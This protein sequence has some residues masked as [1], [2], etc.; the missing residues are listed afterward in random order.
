MVLNLWELADPKKCNSINNL[1]R[2][3]M[4]KVVLI[5]SAL[6]HIFSYGMEKSSPFQGDYNHLFACYLSQKNKLSI[7]FDTLSSFDA[8]YYFCQQDTDPEKS[9]LS[10]LKKLSTIE[11]NKPTKKVE[12]EFLEAVAIAIVKKRFAA[13]PSGVL[14]NAMQHINIGKIVAHFTPDRA[15]KSTFSQ[16]VEERAHEQRALFDSLV[17]PIDGNKQDIKQHIKEQITQKIKEK[18]VQ[19]IAELEHDAEN[20][21]LETYSQRIVSIHN[22]SE[23]TN[24]T[25]FFATFNE[26]SSL[27]PPDKELFFAKLYHKTPCLKEIFKQF[28]SPDNKSITSYIS[29]MKKYLSSYIPQW[30]SHMSIAENTANPTPQHTSTFL[31]WGLEKIAHNPLNIEKSI[32]DNRAKFSIKGHSCQIYDHS[33]FFKIWTTAS[34]L[35]GG[36]LIDVVSIDGKLALLYDFNHASKKQD[37]EKEKE[38][39]TYISLVDLKKRKSGTIATEHS[40]TKLPLSQTDGSYIFVPQTD[41]IIEWNKKNNMLSK[42]TFIVGEKL[43]NLEKFLYSHISEKEIQDIEYYNKSNKQYLKIWYE[44]NSKKCVDPNF[45]ILKHFSPEK[46]FI[47]HINSDNWKIHKNNKPLFY[48]SQSPRIMV[49]KDKNRAEKTP[50]EKTL[51]DHSYK[52]N[53]VGYHNRNILLLMSGDQEYF[54]GHRAYAVSR[55]GYHFVQYNP[56]NNIIKE[57]PLFEQIQRNC[58]YKLIPNSNKILVWNNNDNTLSTHAIEFRND[59]CIIRNDSYITRGTSCHAVF[60]SAINS[61][62]PKNHVIENIA[63]QKDNTIAVSYKN[64][65]NPEIMTFALKSAISKK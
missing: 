10:I 48:I 38:H 25:L 7:N 53:S 59:L 51:Y 36:S 54:Y 63:I 28:Q 55:T 8:L 50:A 34:V 44:D 62:N 15:S 5:F 37:N 20:K 42:Y 22:K 14:H 18:N 52:I 29:S 1:L 35:Y 2:I 24:V 49:Q 23:L 3:F 47:E 46:I 26:L 19:K 16:H 33:F 61:F 9:D 43:I 58:V 45:K 57:Y 64:S 17:E 65:K 4:K 13:V 27:T 56:K 40:H 41:T 11:K 39:G 31:S 12:N 6:L 60:G 32:Q 30:M 21:M